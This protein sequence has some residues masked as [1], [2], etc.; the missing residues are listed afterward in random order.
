MIVHILIGALAMVALFFLIDYTRKNDLHLKW[1]QWVLTV[2]CVL[3]FVF[4]AEV[5]VGFLSEGAMQAALVNGLLT[6]IIG[7]V[8]AVLLGRFVFA[9][10][11][12]TA[13]AEPVEP[14]AASD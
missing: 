11:E 8:W 4:V 5:V 2:L 3:Y 7:I 14:V 13:V 10:A 9:K 1:W 12:K 6:G